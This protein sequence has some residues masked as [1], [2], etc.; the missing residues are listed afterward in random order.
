MSRLGFTPGMFGRPVRIA[1]P[2]IS[3]GSP[4][5]APTISTWQL[6][7]MHYYH[8]F[9][10]QTVNVHYGLN[11][12][13][14]SPADPVTGYDVEYWH[15]NN[16][17]W[18]AVNTTGG[19]SV[20]DSNTAVTWPNIHVG[21][22]SYV[23]DNSTASGG[24]FPYYKF[25]VRATNANGSSSWSEE[26]ATME[27][28]RPKQNSGGPNQ[29]IDYTNGNTTVVWT[30]GYSGTVAMHN[31]DYTLAEN[32]T[33]P[34]PENYTVTYTNQNLA[35]YNTS[36]MMW[37]AAKN[38][39]AYGGVTVS[40]PA[41]VN[42]STPRELSAP[43]QVT[44]TS[45]TDNGNGTFAIAFTATARTAT[46]E[47]YVNDISVGGIASGGGDVAA[48]SGDTIRVDSISAF[49]VTAGANSTAP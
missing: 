38:V 43:D 32:V 7:D 14:E 30:N 5:A 35:S 13:L 3:G 20:T 39:N 12:T 25:R 19:G 21:N 36:Q 4:P 24:L 42:Y 34:Q 49:G 8:D 48:I 33:Y 26:N 15:V 29:N 37:F 41:T 23:T 1:P 18:S 2:K 11:L 16:G 22:F 10:N 31:L 9:A 47:A 28:C 17:S 46:Y 27:F 6:R 45:V 44:L 40:F